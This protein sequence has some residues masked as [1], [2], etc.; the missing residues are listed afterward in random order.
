MLTIHV[1]NDSEFNKILDKHKRLTIVT[2]SNDTYT[3][4]NIDDKDIYVFFN[5]DKLNLRHNL[6]QFIRLI[7]SNNYHLFTNSNDIPD[8][9][10]NISIIQ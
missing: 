6:H 10:R 2:L 1:N 3:L 9:I 5:R 7:Q 8:V 4:P